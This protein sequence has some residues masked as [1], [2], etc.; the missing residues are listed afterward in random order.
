M[1][2]FFIAVLPALLSSFLTAK[3]MKGNDDKKREADV[4][5]NRRALAKALYSELQ[6]LIKL[7]GGKDDECT[8]D[9]MK[10]SAEPPEQGKDVKI[11]YIY[12][13]I[14]FLF[15]KVNSGRLDC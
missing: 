9:N 8:A 15:M 10:V 12:H 4:V 7:Y 1:R 2:D 3:F 5:N 11:A 13:K 14:M 6:A